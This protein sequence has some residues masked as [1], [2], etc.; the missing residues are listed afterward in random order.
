MTRSI[1]VAVLL[2]CAL[3]WPAVRAGE[4]HG[5]VSV[6]ATV[7]GF[8]DIGGDPSLRLEDGLLD[9]GLHRRIDVATDLGDR[10]LSQPIK[11]NMLLLCSGI[12]VS[13]EVS[14]GY[15]LHATGKQRN[16]QG[17]NG[18]LIP[19]ELLRGSSPSDG[20]WDDDAYPVNIVTGRSGSIPVYGYIVSLP[21]NAGDG[22]YTDT[23]TV[24]VDF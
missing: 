14:F 12:N 22:L 9:F 20:L 3:G 19:Y 2:A 15:G 18:T 5:E 6:A 8:C 21:A 7:T 17:P 16:L 24:R 10:S 13:P 4:R 1:L 23:V 11:G